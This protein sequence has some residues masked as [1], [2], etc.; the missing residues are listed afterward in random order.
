LTLFGV[1]EKNPPLS[2]AW[3]NPRRH[4]PEVGPFEDHRWKRTVLKDL[5]SAE[6]K[7]CAGEKIR[8]GR[9]NHPIVIEPGGK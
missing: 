8:M 9:K 4:E 7:G 6:Q 5:L 2:G 1:G 3:R